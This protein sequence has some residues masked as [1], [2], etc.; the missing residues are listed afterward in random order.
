MERKVIC[1]LL[2]GLVAG[3]AGALVVSK[4]AFP[5]SKVNAGRANQKLDNENTNNFRGQEAEAGVLVN[6][7]GFE[8]EDPNNIYGHAFI[9][10]NWYFDMTVLVNNLEFHTGHKFG[11]VGKAHGSP[12]ALLSEQIEFMEEFLAKGERLN[13]NRNSAEQSVPPKSDRAGG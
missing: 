1:A 2:V 4:A 12:Q 6:M 10:S 8:K 3:A 13:K 5:E 11:P 7:S 9:L